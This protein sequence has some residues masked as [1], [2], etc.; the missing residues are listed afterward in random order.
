MTMST[1]SQSDRNDLFEVGTQKPSSI[2][3]EVR[4]AIIE[5]APDLDADDLESSIDLHEDVGLDSIDLLNIAS[6]IADRIGF[7]I[8][9]SEISRLNTVG[10][11]VEF[12]EQNS[13]TSD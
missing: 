10:D 3:D 7:A 11:L 1:E 6:A 4:A 8:P 9:E 2:E 13:E 12:I 5:V